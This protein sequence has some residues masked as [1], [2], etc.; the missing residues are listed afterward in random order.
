MKQLEE[1][2]M[3]SVW[4]GDQFRFYTSCLGP[5]EDSFAID[6][7]NYC[8]S[9][10]MHH[11][12]GGLKLASINI[13]SI[14]VLGGTFD[15]AS[16]RLGNHSFAECFTLQFARHWN[17]QSNCRAVPRISTAALILCLFDIANIQ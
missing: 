9:C 11:Q 15:A 4:N 14:V 7:W 13:I 2:Y 17:G 10:S 5:V 1:R 12:Q 6:V 3:T 16:H 8:I